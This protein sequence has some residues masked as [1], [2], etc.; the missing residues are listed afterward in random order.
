MAR[1]GVRG[2]FSQPG[3]SR[4]AAAVRLARTLGRMNSILRRC[5]LL[6]L[7]VEAVA[8]LFYSW[9]AFGL[10]T[11]HNA[12]TAVMATSPDALYNF[13]VLAKGTRVGFWLLILFIAAVMAV[14][15]ASRWRES[16]P[17]RPL[18]KAALMLP[19]ATLVGV[20]LFLGLPP[21]RSECDLWP[22]LCTR[23]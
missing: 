17:S 19:V 5:L 10:S 1:P 7:L 16:R 13:Q 23:P 18:L 14:G 11:W 21:V 2:T 3:P 8:C 6:L 12:E 20:W 9:Q 22:S 4:P 15:V